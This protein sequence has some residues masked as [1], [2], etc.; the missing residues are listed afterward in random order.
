M[1]RLYSYNYTIICKKIQPKLSAGR[2]QS[3]CLKLVVDR[4]KEIKDFVPE[5]Y[6]NI[7]ANARKE[8]DKLAFKIKK[9]S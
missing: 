1:F 4:E 7:Y 3:V 2:V 6:W 9:P 5:E 8:G